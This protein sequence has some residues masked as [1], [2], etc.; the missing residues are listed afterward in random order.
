MSV[1]SV[2]VINPGMTPL[3]VINPGMTPLFVNKG[4]NTAGFNKLGFIT[5][6]LVNPDLRQ[7][8]VMADTL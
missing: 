8:G 1:L 5:K 4:C 3:L 7:T 6:P 2:L